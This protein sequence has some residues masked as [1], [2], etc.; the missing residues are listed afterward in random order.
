MFILFSLVPLVVKLGCLF[1]IFFLFSEVSFY[2]YKFPSR[3]CF[4]CC[5]NPIMLWIIMFSFSFVSQS[6]L[7][8]VAQ[9]CPTLCD[10]MDS[11]MPGFPVHHQLPELSQA[12]VHQV[13]DATQPSHPLPSP[14]LPSIFP[15]VR[16]FSSESVLHIRWPKYWSF[17]F[18]ICPSSEHPGLTSFRMD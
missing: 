6:Q 3:N 13:C 14:S 1:E 10:P 18:S 12:H 5:S 16:V 7:S 8:S 9:S 17:R 15:S 2:C 11:S 4:S